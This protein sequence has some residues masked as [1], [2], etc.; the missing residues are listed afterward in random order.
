VSLYSYFRYDNSPHHPH[1]ATFP[2]HKHME[3]AVIEAEAPDLT[4][5]LREVDAMIYPKSESEN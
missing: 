1:L 5:V 3:D 2:S 4:D